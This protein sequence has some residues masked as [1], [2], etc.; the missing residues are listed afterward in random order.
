[1]PDILS[2]YREAVDAGLRA[3][4]APGD[5]EDGPVLDMLRYHMGWLDQEFKPVA[6]STGKGV[7]P[8]LCLYACEAVGGDWH[9]AVPSAVSIELF[10]NFSLVH[11]DIQDGGTERHHRPTVWY[12]WGYSHGLNSGTALNMLANQALPKLA[13]GILSP[14][15]LL[16]AT[17][18][19]TQA[20][21]EMIEG[22]TLD[23]SFERTPRVSTTD[24]LVMIE[25]KTGALLEACL[26]MGASLGTED[27][28][29]ISA[30]RRFGHAIGRLFQVRD[31]ML[32]VWG[33]SEATGKPVASD[34]HRRKKSLPVVHALEHA[35]LNASTKQFPA[36][37]RNKDALTEADVA[38][39][40]SV[41]DELG[42]HRF[43]QQIAEAEAAA[44]MDALQGADL[45]A[46]AKQ[47][48][49]ELVEFLL[50]RDF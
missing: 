15:R 37:Y 41:L 24:Y 31:D 3:S 30:M 18:I 36:I 32:G 11:D 10:H 14:E 42:T 19:L 23:M 50:K 48:G 43:C 2:R 47:Q 12:V 26:H 22:Q 4:L 25:K 46:W 13:R 44:A 33:E 27:E 38:V 7:R 5:R 1:M 16:G 17:R 45:S 6:A 28:R 21:M 34:L 40:L 8:A 20:G 9:V 35:S 39:L 29:L 49:S